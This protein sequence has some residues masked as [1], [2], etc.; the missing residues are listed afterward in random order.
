MERKPPL[1][2]SKF[3]Q[4]LAL[5][6]AARRETDQK[7]R[8]ERIEAAQKAIHERMLELAQE[9]DDSENRD[10]MLE[11]FLIDVAL[12]NLRLLLERSEAA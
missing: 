7:K 6:H 3:E 10:S 9:G 2:D 11:R 4:W 12:M 5:F 1:P 8:K